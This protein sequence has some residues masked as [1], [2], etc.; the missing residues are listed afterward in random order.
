M[1]MRSIFLAALVAGSLEDS[2]AALEFS[3]YLTSNGEIQ[4]LLT[5]LDTGTKSRWLTIGDSFRGH[6]LVTFEKKRDAL[7]LDQ[8]GMS[9]EVRLKGSRAIHSSGG[10]STKA[11]ISVM[12][13]DEGAFVLDGKALNQLALIE[14][15][16]KL[17]LAGQSIALTILTPT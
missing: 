13:S 17:A 9:I 6:V 5:D 4:F 16:E 1:R 3:A 14:H 7:I 11:E 2:Y 8:G 12:I 15:F 10:G